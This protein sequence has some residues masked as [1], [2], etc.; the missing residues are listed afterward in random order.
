MNKDLNADVLDALAALEVIEGSA[1]EETATVAT[2]SEPVK[3]EEFDDV[4][5]LLA[6]LESGTALPTA[7]DESAKEEGI[8]TET[9][10]VSMEPVVSDE[11]L[12]KIEKDLMLEE[13]KEEVYA[14]AESGGL[15]EHELS[16][17]EEPKAKAR[18]SGASKPSSALIQRLGNVDA[19]YKNLVYVP[20][21]A[22]K[23]AAELK[24]ECDA[25]LKEF[26]ALPKKVGEKAVNLVMHLAGSAKLSTYTEIAIQMLLKNG[27]LTQTELFERYRARPYSEGTSR[28]QAGQIMRLFQTL[29]VGVGTT[30]SLT[31]NKDSIIAQALEEIVGKAA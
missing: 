22:A 28:S 19:V 14:A 16:K 2:V 4:D 20:E 7:S 11:A 21:D 18:A 31:L 13:V 24:A 3:S 29:K 6:E 1:V 8:K 23:S 9:E 25:R 10:E 26:D 5:A 30:S 15:E 27:S 17:P 12:E